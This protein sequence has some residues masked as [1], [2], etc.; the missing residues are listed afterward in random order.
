M[1]VIVLLVILIDKTVKNLL[2]RLELLVFGK[3][4]NI[5]LLLLGSYCISCFLNRLAETVY[6]DVSPRASR[7]V[8][9]EM[10][11]TQVTWM[12]LLADVMIVDFLT[13]QELLHIR[14]VFRMAFCSLLRHRLYLTVN[15]PDG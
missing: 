10:E 5:I 14:E 3:K 4:R 6:H 8:L 13:P 1:R 2:I 11:C 7:L 9:I 15:V 12:G